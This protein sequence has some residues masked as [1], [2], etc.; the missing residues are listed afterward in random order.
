MSCEQQ[1]G[2][3]KEDEAPKT[4]TDLN[5][6]WHCSKKVGIVKV[7]CKCGYVFCPKHR[8]SETHDCTFD[9]VKQHKEKLMRENPTIAHAKMDKVI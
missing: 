9:Y 6:C 1:P 8:L 3:K 7:A 5:K 4:Q 2:D